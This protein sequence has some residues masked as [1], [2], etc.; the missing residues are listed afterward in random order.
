[1]LGPRV[2]PQGWSSVKALAGALGV[3][4]SALIRKAE[5]D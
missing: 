4:P 5:A 1:M 3:K 2:D